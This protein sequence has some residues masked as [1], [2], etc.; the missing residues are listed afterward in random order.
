MKNIFI[1]CM[2]ALFLCVSF[3]SC[4]TKHCAALEEDMDGYNPKSNKKKRG[5]QEGLWGK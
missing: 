2:L 4:K 5:R 3:T 1:K